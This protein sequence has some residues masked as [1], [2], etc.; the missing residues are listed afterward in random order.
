MNESKKNYKKYKLQHG[1]NMYKLKNKMEK[2]YI[3]TKESDCR[4]E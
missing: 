1:E 3:N 4:K 2:D